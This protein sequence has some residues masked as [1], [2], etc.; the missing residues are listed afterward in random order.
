[1]EHKS[2]EKRL[3]KPDWKQWLP[4]YGCVKITYNLYKNM[5]TIL[6]KDPSKEPLIFM[7][8]MISF[9]A[10]TY[11]VLDELAKLVEKIF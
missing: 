4:V 11:V 6:D 3:E 8:H 5:P 1:M 2:L 9:G 10:G 7:Y